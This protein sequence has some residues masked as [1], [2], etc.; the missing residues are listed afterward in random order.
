[1]AAAGF[2]VDKLFVAGG[3]VEG[4][5]HIRLLIYKHLLRRPLPNVE[6]VDKLIER[7]HRGDRLLGLTVFAVASR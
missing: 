1:L 2:S 7:S 3:A 4:L 5:D 6:L